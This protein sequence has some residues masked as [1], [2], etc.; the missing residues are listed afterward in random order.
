MLTTNSQGAR[1]E[2]VTHLEPI[3]VTPVREKGRL[4]EGG[5]NEVGKN[6]LKY[7]LKVEQTYLHSPIPF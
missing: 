1:T 2:A 6:K 3:S 4:D 5:G 7:I